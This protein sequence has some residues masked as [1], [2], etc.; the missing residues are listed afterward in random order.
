MD[1][2]GGVPAIAVAE[3]GVPGVFTPAAGVRLFP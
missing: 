1:D 3:Q 2:G